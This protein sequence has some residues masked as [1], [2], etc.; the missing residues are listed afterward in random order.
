MY[1]SVGPTLGMSINTDADNWLT[2]GHVFRWTGPRFLF[3]PIVRL[4]S[5]GIHLTPDG[6]IWYGLALLAN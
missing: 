6:Q 3:G 2:P 5:D 4:R 1:K